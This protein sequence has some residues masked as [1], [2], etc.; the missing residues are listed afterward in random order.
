M[1]GLSN[2]FLILVTF[3]DP[4]KVSVELPINN[5]S[6]EL[7]DM[8]R[9]AP[10]SFA[11]NLPDPKTNGSDDKVTSMILSAS[12]AEQRNKW[13]ND[14]ELAA[15]RMRHSKEPFYSTATG[16]PTHTMHVTNVSV[17]D[18]ER[19]YDDSKM[20]QNTTT[21]VCWFRYCTLGF[22]DHLNMSQNVMAGYLMRK[23]KNKPSD[24]PNNLEQQVIIQGGPPIRA[25]TWT[26]I[27]ACTCV[28]V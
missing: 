26:S 14:V 24:P 27:R 7:S 28:V 2:F 9:S 12:S 19:S 16:Q 8:E 25:C 18:D 5:L 15:N 13:I 6:V 3:L 10:H 21:Q 17:A 20:K 1:D 23:F 4:K 11:L 22:E